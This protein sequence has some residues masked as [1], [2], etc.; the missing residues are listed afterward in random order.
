MHQIFRAFLPENHATL[1]HIVSQQMRLI[2]FELFVNGEIVECPFGAN[3]KSVNSFE[4][5]N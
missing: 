3:D 4:F 2:V 5:L 1:I